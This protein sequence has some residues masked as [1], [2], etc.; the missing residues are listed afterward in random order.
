[1]YR[2]SGGTEDIETGIARIEAIKGNTIAWNQLQSPASIEGSKTQNG[3]TYTNDGKGS[4]S[5]IGEASDDSSLEIRWKQDFFNGHSFL[6]KGCPKNGSASSYRMYISGDYDYGNGLIIK[7]NTGALNVQIQIHSGAVISTPVIFRPIFFDLTLIYG[8]G[9]EPTSA[10]QFEADYFRWFGKPLTY[11]DYDAGSLRSVMMS[12]IKTIGFN[13]WDG[14]YGEGYISSSGG[15][16]AGD[17]TIGYH[18]DYILVLPETNYYNTVANVNKTAFYDANKKYISSN[19]YNAGSIITTPAN[20][21]YV[22]FD[23]RTTVDRNTICFNISNPSKNGTY[24]PYREN[25]AS[26]PITTLTGKL[27][28][29]GASVTIFPDGMKSA[30]S[31]R[32]EIFVDNGVVKAIKRVGSV[33]MG[34]LTWIKST[35]TSQNIPVFYVVISNRKDGVTNL[36]CPLYNT[37]L[38]ISEVDKTITGM[39]HIIAKNV[40]VHDTSYTDASTFKNAMQGVMLY[41]ELAEPLVYELDITPQD[42]QK[43]YI[44]NDPVV[45]VYK[46]DT[47]LWEANN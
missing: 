5:V 46:G 7:K 6:F 22:R 33:D 27:N 9:N 37:V 41:Y 28:G 39:T 16:V 10:E 14:T 29:E 40:V 25:I 30:G 42:L 17:A 31:I 3:I 15:A 21:H 35:A 47:L 8:A 34:D 44:G 32:D 12:G 1:M 13:Q 24:E 18:S 4:V 26:L 23:W 38:A 19:Y 36:L 11:E 45:R 2:K 43:R 20:C